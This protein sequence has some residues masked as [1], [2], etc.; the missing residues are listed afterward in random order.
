[1]FEKM[2]TLDE[3]RSDGIKSEVYEGAGNTLK[4]SDMVDKVVSLA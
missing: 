2:L 3:K 1:M 4:I